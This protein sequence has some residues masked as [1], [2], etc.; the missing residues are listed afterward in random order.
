MSGSS[1]STRTHEGTGRQWG[2]TPSIARC[3]CTIG[4]GRSHRSR[5]GVWRGWSLGRPFRPLSLGALGVVQ[6]RFQRRHEVHDAGRRSPFGFDALAVAA[7]DAGAAFDRLLPFLERR[8]GL[9]AFTAER[10]HQLSLRVEAP[11]APFGERPFAAAAAPS[12]AAF[13]LVD[14]RPM[15]D[16]RPPQRRFG[17]WIVGTFLLR[18]FTAFP[19]VEGDGVGL[20]MGG[21]QVIGPRWPTKVVNR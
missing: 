19:L 7:C 13:Q 20:V 9:A 18:L 8:D 15:L 2:C 6:R 21:V 14:P 17:L 3:R 11:V 16:R 10:L 1:G 5:R 4:T 12:G